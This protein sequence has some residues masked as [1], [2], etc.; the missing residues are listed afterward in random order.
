MGHMI[1]RSIEAAERDRFTS[2]RDGADTL[3][4]HVAE[5]FAG[6]ATSEGWC[7]VAEEG[8]RWLGRAFLRAAPKGNEQIFVHFF[9]VD[10]DEP[11]ADAVARSLIDAALEAPGADDERTLL[12][13]LDDPHPWHPEPRRRRG[14]FE[15]AGFTLARDALRWEWPK[16]RS[17]PASRGTLSFRP[18]EE[19]GEAAFLAAIASVSDGTLDARLREM[20]SRLGREDDAAEHFR[21]LS[22]LRHAPGWFQLAYSDEELAGLIA[23]AG[24]SDVVFV[25][26]VGVV[27]E[28]RGRGLVDELLA[29]ATRMLVD[30]GEETIRADT[31]AANAP[32]AKAFERSGYQCILARTE[33]V[34]AA[35]ARRALAA[36]SGGA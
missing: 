23:C 13:A 33:L 22:S 27:P 16:G 2:L 4:R 15:Q 12:F 26:Y 30:A 21:L 34:M 32:M 36:R 14:W 9:D 20:R 11:Q 31:D 24:G 25:A 10:L 7:L 8:D 18:I 1:V 28:L 29:Q 17:L 6:G 3:A 19:V 35:S 5:A